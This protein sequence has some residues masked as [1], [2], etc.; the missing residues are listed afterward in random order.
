MKKIIIYISLISVVMINIYLIFFWQ[1][2]NKKTVIEETSKE[3]VSYAKTLYK[4]DKESMLVLL[5]SEDKKKLEKIMKK[6]STFDMGKIK[7]YY[8]D[9]NEEEGLINI[10]R[11]LRKRLSSEDYK[12]IEEITSSFI[13]LDKINEEI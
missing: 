12:K 1:T 4:V 11:L 2:Q 7:E 10:F 3:T 9:N 5:S 6:L 8:E 13:E